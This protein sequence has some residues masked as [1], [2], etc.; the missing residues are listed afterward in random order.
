M[1]RP[2]AKP[3]AR[4]SVI[5]LINRCTFSDPRTAIR[6]RS[7]VLQQTPSPTG[8]QGCYRPV[9]RSRC[10]APMLWGHCGTVDVTQTYMWPRCVSPAWS[11]V[12][13][14]G[15]QTRLK[16][17]VR[18]PSIHAGLRGAHPGNPHG[19]CYR[20]KSHDK[21]VA[22]R[23]TC[24]ATASCRNA[25]SS[26]NSRWSCPRLSR[27]ASA[28]PASSAGRW[29]PSAER[30]GTVPTHCSSL[31]HLL[32]LRAGVTL[33]TRSNTAAMP[34]PPPMHIVTSA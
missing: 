24:S 29:T 14:A 22:P 9:H 12:A 10:M 18:K 2:S 33:Q 26:A 19:S 28:A 30:P 3:S 20:P 8:D 13:A 1:G 15:C 34:W 4:N 25:A 7:G 31:Q 27:T 17:V 21:Q 32:E 11:Q 5:S 16:G 23:R 6:W